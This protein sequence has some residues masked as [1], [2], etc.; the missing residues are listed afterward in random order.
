MERAISYSG[1]IVD[2]Y[3]DAL[4]LQIS[5]LGMEKLK[6]LVIEYLKNQLKPS[7]IYEKSVLPS[8]KEE[9]SRAC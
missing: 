5:T 8:R 9:G 6:P 2:R 7:F 1:L 4:I 3:D